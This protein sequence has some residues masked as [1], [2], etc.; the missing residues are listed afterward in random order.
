[1]RD[2]LGAPQ[3]VLLLG[4]TSEIGLA[5]LRRVLR[6]GRTRQVLLGGRDP[7]ALEVAAKDLAAGDGPEV[8]VLRFDAADDPAAHEAFVAEATAGGDLD[9]VLVAFGL[10][11]DQERSEEDAA[12]ARRV[13]EVNFTGAV[14]VLVP[15]LRALRAQGHGTVAVFSSVAAERPR[16]AN[17]TYGAA[18]AGLDAWCQGMADRLAGT[19]VR[20]MVVRP[21]FVHTKMTAGMRPAP[22][23]TH[24]DAVAEATWRGLVRGAQ[25]V[26]APPALRWVMAGLRHLPRP[27][28]RR[29]PG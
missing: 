15:L 24:P 19:G 18:K 21:G 13:I 22:F 26:W 5:T 27:L 4:G 25:T 28:W 7:A 9:L 3:S 6:A 23:A 10:L 11:G 16:R 20:L 1:M 14:S 8:R 29:L 12:E 17:F 2:A